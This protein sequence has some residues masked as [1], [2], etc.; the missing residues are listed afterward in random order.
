MFPGLTKGWEL[1]RCNEGEYIRSDILHKEGF[2]HGFF[3]RNWEEKS[4]EVL[5]KN[6]NA[7]AS[8]HMLA[9]IHSNKILKAPLASKPPWPKADCLISDKEKQSLW[10]Y[11]A[12]CIPVL[13]ADQ[14]NGYAAA[15]HS[16]WKGI[17]KRIIPNAIQELELIGSNIKN[18]VVALGQSISGKKYQVDSTTISEIAK[19]LFQNINQMEI[20]SKEKILQL[21]TQEIIQQDVDLNK[22]MLDLRIA[23][24]HQIKQLGIKKEQISLCPL[25][26]FSESKLFNSWRRNQKKIIQW[27]GIVSKKNNQTA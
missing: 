15:C 2:N 9:Q 24:I 1:I 25:C 19:G 7:N 3:S 12:D 4:P 21:E 14:A 5:I 11:S 20:L 13:I 26:T 22:F 16:G 23:A 10:I 8:I 27:S 18:L 17:S 6:L